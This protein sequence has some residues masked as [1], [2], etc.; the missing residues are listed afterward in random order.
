MNNTIYTIG[1]TGFSINDFLRILKEYKIQVVI[2]VRS[3]P[4][5]E[6]YPDY[7]RP[8]FEKKLNNNGIYYRNYVEEF[9]ARQENPLY[10]TDG[11]LDFN[12]FS[13]TNAFQRGV[14]KIRNSLDKNYVITFL[15]AEK[16]P[17]QCHR[18]ILVSRAF[19]DLGY[20]VYHI[21][22]SGKCE[23]QHDIEQQLLAMYFPNGI[24]QD[25]FSE[26]IDMDEAIDVAYRKQNQKIG[27]QNEGET[28]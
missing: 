1:Y 10:Y 19:S 5:S 24:Q 11:Y 21:L 7:N 15:C 16:N 2:D 18:A 12:K 23:T 27:Y 8:N 4:Y 28:V 6:R 26:P 22:P 14:T 13:K 3:S 17:I 20:Q 25:I 9:G